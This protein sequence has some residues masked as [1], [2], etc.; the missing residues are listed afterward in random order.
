MEQFLK[1]SEEL[2]MIESEQR[3]TLAR[4]KTAWAKGHENGFW[5][6][7]DGNSIQPEEV[8]PTTLKDFYTETD[9]KNAEAQGYFSGWVNGILSMSGLPFDREKMPILGATH[10]DATNPY[11][12]SKQV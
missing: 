11:S 8:A 6:A 10:R 3:F 2:N 1:I 9:V 5:I 4:M 12:A 7:R